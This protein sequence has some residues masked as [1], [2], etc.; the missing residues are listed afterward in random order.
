MTKYWIQ[1]QL[2][3]QLKGIGIALLLSACQ[4]QTTTPPYDKAVSIAH[5]C[6]VL[7][8]QIAAQYDQLTPNTLPVHYKSKT[9]TRRI[10]TLE[11]PSSYDV[12]FQHKGYQA[13]IDHC[14]LR[15]QQ[16]G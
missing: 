2:K 1:W 14:L 11:L 8:D 13:V 16:S 15:H 4:S 5:F 7:A 3:G 12:I 9:G 6:E 10:I